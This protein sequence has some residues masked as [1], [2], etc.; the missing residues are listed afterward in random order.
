MLS[1]KQTSYFPGTF[2]SLTFWDW[3]FFLKKKYWPALSKL[4]KLSLYKMKTSFHLFWQYI[5]Y[6]QAQEIL[7]FPGYCQWLHK[8]EI[9]RSHATLCQD[10][11]P[12]HHGPEAGQKRLG[13]ENRPHQILASPRQ[14][15]PAAGRMHQALWLVDL[16]EHLF[17]TSFVVI[18]RCVPH[19]PS[20]R[21]CLLTLVLFSSHGQVSHLL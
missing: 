13:M 12:N 7:R 19:T 4:S 16:P 20:F 9:A 18:H 11:Y 10:D 5:Q 21:N 3:D 15:S 17:A 8:K 14:W 1:R 6:I 2:N